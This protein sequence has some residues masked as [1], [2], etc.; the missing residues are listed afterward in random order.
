MS[1]FI[2]EP[3]TFT[4]LTADQRRGVETI[5]KMATAK[6]VSV[7]DRTMRNKSWTQE[8]IALRDANDMLMDLFQALKEDAATFKSTNGTLYRADHAVED[9]VH[10]MAVAKWE[11][12]SHAWRQSFSV[13]FE[14]G[15]SEAD[16]RE[17]AIQTTV[18]ARQ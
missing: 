18:Q 16:A 14:D 3:G 7:H 4:H 1:T 9:G 10:Y 5:L 2:T 8:A 17:R 13:P 15:E 6:V 11:P 12:A